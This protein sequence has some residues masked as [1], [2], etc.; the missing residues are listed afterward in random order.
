LETIVK[1]KLNTRGPIVDI[2][3]GTNGTDKII[4]KQQASPNMKLFRRV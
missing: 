2:T 4:P 3:G 1:F